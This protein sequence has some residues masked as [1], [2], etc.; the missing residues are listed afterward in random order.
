MFFSCSDDDDNQN[1][2]PNFFIYGDTEIQ[3][4]DGIILDY[5]QYTEGVYN[6]DIVILDS[7]INNMGGEPF[8]ANDT[9]S[10]VEFEL[11]TTNAE[12]LQVG[13]YTFGSDEA[14]SYEYGVVY[15][16]SST[17]NFESL[18]IDSGTFTVL[19][20]G[21]TYEFEF[22][23]TVEDGTEFSGSFKGS[24]EA[25]DF[26]ENLDRLGV[27]SKNKNNKFSKKKK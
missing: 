3:L 10:G 21:S 24:L 4:T 14:N 2:S 15:F 11:F 18:Y 13:T 9:F 17:Q 27:S 12:D 19:D 25:Y 6:F 22:E 16:N 5:G 1:S 23:G 20:N 8:P 7:E 26:S